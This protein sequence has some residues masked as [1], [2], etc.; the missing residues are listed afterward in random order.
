MKKIKTFGLIVLAVVIVIVIF[1]FNGAMG[2]T[3]L[4]E[5]E[6]ALIVEKGDVWHKGSTDNDFQ[7]V[8][9]FKIVSEGDI[10]KT[11]GNSVARISFFDTQEVM[12]AEDSQVVITKGYINSNSP[13]LTKVRVKLQKGQ[14]W[15][16]LMNLLHPSAAFE[17]EAGTVVA[18]VRGTAFNVTLTD[19]TVEV[20][21]YENDVDVSLVG[22][23]AILANMSAGDKLTYDLVKKTYEQETV[24]TDELKLQ[25]KE[26]PWIYNNI[27]M[28]RNF[29]NY[30]ETKRQ[31][32]ISDVGL[33]PDH[34]LY[35]IKTGFEKIR[36]LLSGTESSY[37]QKLETKRGIEI[38]GLIDSTKVTKAIEQLKIAEFNKQT[39]ATLQRLQSFDKE[40]TNKLSRYDGLR[41]VFLGKIFD[42]S[43][44]AFIANKIQ[45]LDSEEVQSVDS[46]ELKLEVEQDLAKPKIEPV[47]IEVQESEPTYGTAD[48]QVPSSESTEQETTV[49]S[50]ATDEPATTGESATLEDPVTTDTPAVT[51]EQPAI[52]DSGSTDQPEE[53]VVPVAQSLVVT[54][55]PASLIPD[56]SSKLS[57]NLI[58]SDG[59]KLDV[60]EQINWSASGD[61]ISG[62]DVGSLKGNIFTANRNGG[63]TTISGTYRPDDNSSF[64]G[65]TT[66]TV[67]LVSTKLRN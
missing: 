17:V 49:E 37:K 8:E 45:G 54:A 42:Q 64:T 5:P 26:E 1:W 58:Y 25:Q 41:K 63:A 67:L 20:F 36:L 60:T 48:D 7:K 52:T 56:A 59:S 15:S 50:I 61:S 38:Q 32:I 53:L 44:A 28:N 57:A 43:V 65:Q 13:L 30:L 35:G 16:R 4:V 40:F 29:E 47:V 39:L 2:R 27:M 55:N 46:G 23:A 34:P 11:N 6:I 33:L 24:G 62:N 12:V 19:I 10:I 31:A 14:V 18:T 22:E 66:I 21:V 9:K 51:E 3:D